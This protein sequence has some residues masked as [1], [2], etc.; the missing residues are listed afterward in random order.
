CRQREGKSC[1]GSLSS[2]TRTRPCGL[3]TLYEGKH[4]RG[5]SW[6][7]LGT[8]TTSRA[9]PGSASTTLTSSSSGS[10]QFILQHGDYPDFFRWN[11]HKDHMGSC[12]P[13]GM[14]SG[15]GHFCLAIFEG[16]SFAG[17]CLQF[18]DDCPF[19]QSQGWAKNCVNAIKVY[20][21]GAWVLGEEPN[22]H[23]RM[24]LVERGHFCSFSS[25][26]A[27]SAHPVPLPTLSFYT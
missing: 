5:G 9:G 19:L 23:G 25:W 15:M 7:S 1:S 2:H 24:S 17:Q 16:C 14:V 20:G 21:D 3:I 4:S 22:D 26:A 11:G 10:Q 6:R 18:E 12:R 27:H 8:V 13:V